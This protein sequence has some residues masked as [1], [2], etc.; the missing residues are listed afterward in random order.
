MR[1]RIGVGRA[2]WA[3]TKTVCIQLQKEHDCT[4]VLD[5]QKGLDDPDALIETLTHAQPQDSIV[6][7]LFCIF[8]LDNSSSSS[9]S[10]SSRNARHCRVPSRKGTEGSHETW[11]RKLCCTTNTVCTLSTT[12]NL[13]YTG[14]MH[15]RACCACTTNTFKL[16]VSKRG[17]L[18][19]PSLCC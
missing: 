14:R 5:A 13:R 19:P 4:D 12:L 11:Y 17:C 7:S 16:T 15:S 10:S 6:K 9:S 2:C 3:N 8:R 1:E 18:P